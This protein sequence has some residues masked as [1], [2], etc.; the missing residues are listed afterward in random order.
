[1]ANDGFE[2]ISKDFDKIIKNTP[3][4]IEKIADNS[5]NNL[6]GRVKL[7]NPKAKKIVMGQE[8]L[9]LWKKQI[10]LYV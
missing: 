6:L 9:G 8:K 10:N 3:E 1:M 2:D 4:E 7:E 5:G